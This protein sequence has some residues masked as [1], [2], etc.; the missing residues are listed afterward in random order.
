MTA[1]ESLGLGACA[2]GAFRDD[3]VNDL[4]DVDGRDEMAV[5]LLAAGTPADRRV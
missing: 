2:V 4:V 3:D 1:A 5:Y